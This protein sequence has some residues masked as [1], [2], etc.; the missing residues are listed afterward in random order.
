[1]LM[2]FARKTFYW[3]T[4][5]VEI[6]VFQTTFFRLE[7][8]LT[9][10]VSIPNQ[11]SFQWKEIFEK[12]KNRNKKLSKYF[13][14]DFRVLNNVFRM[15]TYFLVS[16]RG[17]LSANHIKNFSDIPKSKQKVFIIK[18]AFAF[19]KLLRCFGFIL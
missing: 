13:S 11:L 5:T 15:S 19:A 12:N 1:M 7:A 4:R 6:C 8:L 2:F 16:L 9:K 14:K 10:Y 18:C 17:K 3:N